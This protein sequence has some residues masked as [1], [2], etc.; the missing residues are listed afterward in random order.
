VHGA[1]ALSPGI[2]PPVQIGGW[3][4]PISGLDEVAVSK[5]D[6]AGNVIPV[7]QPVACHY[8]TDCSSF[9][10]KFVLDISLRFMV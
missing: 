8:C 10:G 3:V 5:K 9:S 7:G 4:G 6:A 1:A 2:E